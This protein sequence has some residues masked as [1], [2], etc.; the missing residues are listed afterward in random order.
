[1]VGIGRKLLI[2]M[3]E[4][5]MDEE[6]ETT[7]MDAQQGHTSGVSRAHYAISSSQVGRLDELT[8]LGYYRTSK[9]VHRL[10]FG[11]EDTTPKTK[12]LGSRN[13]SNK[14]SQEYMEQFKEDMESILQG[15]MKELFEKL[16]REKLIDVIKEYLDEIKDVIR[17]QIRVS[18]GTRSEANELVTSNKEDSS[19]GQQDT[20]MRTADI[21]F[22]SLYDGKMPSMK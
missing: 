22:D 5:E 18:Q 10:V 3:V 7:L 4:D 8:M 1:M 20:S 17:S 6:E 16:A 21:T 2:R 15:T 19:Q 12:G 9:L 14:I 13:S 11:I